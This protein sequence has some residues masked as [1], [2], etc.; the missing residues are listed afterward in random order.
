MLKIYNIV[1]PHY[2]CPGHIQ[3]MGHW[4]DT[5]VLEHM[6]Q[7]FFHEQNS[8]VYLKCVLMYI[9]IHIFNLNHMNIGENPNSYDKS[10]HRDIILHS[11][12]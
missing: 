4:L 11:N 2:S 7:Y 5:P 10:H 1:G 6:N 12:R 8:K 9:E 3:L